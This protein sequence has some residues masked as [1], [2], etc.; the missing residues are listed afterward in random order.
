MINKQSF[1]KGTVILAAANA[2]SKI[3]GAV[4]KIPLTYFLQEEGMAIY[5]TAFS[6]YIMLLSFV[7][8]GAPL[9][10]SKMIAEENALKNTANVKKNNICNRN[11][12]RHCRTFGN[13]CFMVWCRFF[14]LCRERT[15]ICFLYKNT[16][17]RYI[18]R[19]AR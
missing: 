6:V 3:L 9:A 8:S 19:C 13:C 10:I 14:C 17:S 11:T 7:T 16:L 18:F 5:S 4:F 12:S 1:I 15:K 2:I